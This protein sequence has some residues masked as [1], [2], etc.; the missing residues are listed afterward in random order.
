MFS[1]F[2]KITTPIYAFIEKLSKI[3]RL[4]LF[5]CV[6]FVVFGA[7]VWLSF[8]PNFGK[9]NQLNEEVKDLEQKL[10]I[11]TR[12]AKQ[13][14]RYRQMLA[15]KEA[16]F[17]LAK[18]ALPEKKEI[19][20]LLTG[21]STAGKTAGLEFFLFQPR[22]EKK[23]D[24]YAEIPVSIRVRGPYHNVAI[25]FDKV[26]RLFRVVNITDIVMDTRKNTDY[27][28]TSCTAITYRFIE[29]AAAEKAKS[30]KSKK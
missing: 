23:Q 5:G 11:A 14:P 20:S 18:N 10:T 27:L 25:F 30:K 22:E 9:I 2:S 1:I 28:D 12:K 17:N 15:D 26:S 13:L 16:E 21:I 29:T 7:F 6:F 19:P 8:Y 24:F 4:A 3:Q